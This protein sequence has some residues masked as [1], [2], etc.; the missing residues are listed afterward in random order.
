MMNPTSSW[1]TEAP[2]AVLW[3]RWSSTPSQSPSTSSYSNYVRPL[4][5]PLIWNRCSKTRASKN[6]CSNNLPLWQT[7]VHMH[8]HTTVAAPV[9]GQN[10]DNQIP[11]KARMD[12]HARCPFPIPNT[13]DR[14]PPPQRKQARKVAPPP[15]STSPPAGSRTQTIHQ[16]TRLPRRLAGWC[17]QKSLFGGSHTARPS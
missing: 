2:R 13:L 16:Q 9:T 12:S 7:A 4:K 3:R 8:W 1:S 14:Y 5:M 10:L 11:Q 6:N 17:R 15:R